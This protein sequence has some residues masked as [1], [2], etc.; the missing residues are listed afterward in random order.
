MLNPSRY[1]PVLLSLVA[2]TLMAQ[3]TTGSVTGHVTSKSGQPLAGALIRIASPKL[4][5][6]RTA[7][8]DA[9]GQ[10]RIPIIPGGQYTLT[11]TVKDYATSKGTFQVLAGQ[12]SK[13]DAVLTPMAELQKVQ[14]ATVEVVADATQEDKTQMVT[15]TILSV[16]QIETI[17]SASDLTAITGLAPGIANKG[18]NPRIRG[19]S[20]Q[21][22]KWLLNGATVSVGMTGGINGGD[23]TIKDLLESSAV[24]QSA[25]NAR[26]GGTDGGLVSLVTKKGSNTWGGSL[27]AAYSTQ[28]TM[29]AT[30][31]KYSNRVGA[32]DS[33][34]AKGDDSQRH[35][36]VT[37]SGPLWKDHI[38]FAYGGTFQPTT[39]S[40]SLLPD[41]G[42]PL[43][44]WDWAS[45]TFDLGGGNLAH[46]ANTYDMGSIYHSETKTTYNQ[47]IVYWQITSNQQL[48]WNYS[49]KDY[50]SPNAG[51]LSI[52]PS[53]AGGP[54]GTNTRAWNL[55]YKA[56]IGGNGLLEAQFG[57][58]Y[59]KWYHYA[60]PGVPDIYLP[61][62]S[63]NARSLIDL[64]SGGNS[65]YDMLQY[66]STWWTWDPTLGGVSTNGA[67]F[68]DRG[69]T[70]IDDTLVINYEH[71][72]NIGSSSHQID[73]GMNYDKSS[74]NTQAKAQY[75]PENF[76]AS[77]QLA[78]D[79]TQGEL[80]AGVTP[81]DVNG[82]YIVMNW[83]ATFGD[84]GETTNP[85]DTVW[86]NKKAIIPH[87]YVFKG[88]EDGTYSQPTTSF[89]LN[90]LWTIN[91]N[92]SIML[93]LRYDHWS[94]QDHQLV[95]GT[96]GPNETLHSYNRF[97]P[98]FEYKW[99][100][101]GDQSR[102][103]NFSVAQFH[104]RPASAQFENVVNERLAYTYMYYWSATP[105]A[106]YSLG[107][108]GA[109]ATFQTPG[110]TNSNAPYLVGKD[111]LTDPRNYGKLDYFNGPAS[112]AL[113]KSWKAPLVTE[114][115]LGLHRSYAS[116]MSWRATAVYK[117]WKDLS[118][119]F[120]AYTSTQTKNELGVPA[121][122]P[123]DG[124]PILSYLSTMRIDPEATK[125]YKGL[126][127]EWS[128]PFSKALMFAGNYTYSRTMTD[129]ASLNEYPR[130]AFNPNWRDFWEGT[131][132]YSRSAYNPIKAQDPEHNAKVWFIYDLSRPKVKSSISFFASYLS[133]NPDTRNQWMETG[134]PNITG[135]NGS[136]GTPHWLGLTLA[137]FTK[138]AS[139]TNSVKY[140]LEFDLVR[141]FKMFV[142]IEV[143]NPFNTRMGSNGDWS[144]LSFNDGNEDPKNPYYLTHGFRAGTNLSNAGVGNSRNTP[145]Y[146]TLE[147]GFR[148]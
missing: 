59:R 143:M 55:S 87:R 14:Q 5:G 44:D 92:H 91:Q 84:L 13:A 141:G 106:T 27:R 147:T 39:R 25:K 116:G 99:D 134:Y 126:E 50:S 62:G 137:G 145:R 42:L 129:S 67:S 28:G 63:S 83:N 85:A 73:V 51:Y 54:D 61:Y 76:W 12:T 15:Q 111:Q 71:I 95:N 69:D 146:F 80:P 21:G 139:F 101:F 57:R 47:F 108:P 68:G 66:T 135:D 43:K 32:V 34:N 2:A 75:P 9:R 121:T 18:E 46:R 128:I 23:T 58:T 19:G 104:P 122:N 100:I 93:G 65:A 110:S 78:N 125:T 45:T 103:L 133:G 132:G 113:D 118:D 7:V 107:Q 138:E 41:N 131:L 70:M 82:K 49:Q 52:D 60:T 6:E 31:V 11:A 64:N 119:W 140:N 102:L 127:L 38:T 1:T 79:Y 33:I 94:L 24:V 53:H 4:L 109:T 148:F 74:W 29:E 88:A 105:G 90:D 98:R 81:A 3:E 89:Y 20:S 96:T 56:I 136:L 17:T 114:Y 10:Y 142:E 26:Y 30:P 123:S 22:A 120:P 117:T 86:G 115:T 144:Q 8:T 130:G 16:D 72:L 35:Y 48:E 37:V 124:S 40:A 36:D 77:G 97:T 112:F